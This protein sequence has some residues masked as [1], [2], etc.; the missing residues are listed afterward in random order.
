M[1]PP[2]RQKVAIITGASQGIG[3]GLVAEFRASWYAVVG[4]SRSIPSSEKPDYLTVPVDIAELETPRHV[5]EQTLDRFGGSQPDQ[6]R[7]SGRLRRQD[8]GVNGER[9]ERFAGFGQG[10]VALTGTAEHC[11]TVPWRRR[12]TELARLLGALTITSP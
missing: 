5:V 10:G 9:A 12:Q 3:A 11:S 7:G 6:Q 8:R 4:T 1:N 2:E